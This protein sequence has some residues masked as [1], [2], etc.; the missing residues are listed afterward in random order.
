MMRNLVIITLSILLL[1]GSNI[2]ALDAESTTQKAVPLQNS[3]TAQPQT[4]IPP[5]TTTTVKVNL[6]QKLENIS[7]L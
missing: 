1:I 4:T 3:T 2:G 5:T 7:I 6:C